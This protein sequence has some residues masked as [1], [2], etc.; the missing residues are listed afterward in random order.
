MIRHLLNMIWNQ[1]K[2]NGWIVAEI[3]LVFVALWYIIDTLMVLGKVYY[4]PMGWDEGV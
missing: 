2:R 3:L 4:S 1:R